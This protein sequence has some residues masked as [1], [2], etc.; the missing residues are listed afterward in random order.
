VIDPLQIEATIHAHAPQF[1]CFE[2]D[3]PDAEGMSALAHTRLHHPNLPVLMITGC[4]SEA[5][6]IWALRIRVWDLLVKPLSCELLNQRISALTALTY[7][8]KQRAG[9]ENLFLRPVADDFVVMN[10]YEKHKKTHPAITHV[11]QHFDGNIALSD[12]ASMCHCGTTHFCR[13]FRQEHGQSFHQYLLH[14][15]IDQARDR[16]ANPHSHAKEVAYEVGFNDL[17]YFAR[18]FKR[19]VGVCPS[20]YR[21]TAR[22]S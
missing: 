22:L 21:A 13:I 14:Y 8:T 12:V 5:V 6:A 15:R 9:Y 10:G 2:F 19:Q 20:E 7:S 16:L 17:S 1:L 18:A 3:E 4:H 11:A